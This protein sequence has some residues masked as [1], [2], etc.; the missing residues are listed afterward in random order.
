MSLCKVTASQI[1]IPKLKFWLV[2]EHSSQ[3]TEAVPGWTGAVVLCF[4]VFLGFT[5]SFLVLQVTSKSKSLFV[6]RH[7]PLPGQTL[8]LAA[9]CSG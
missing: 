8:L 3:H 5:A 4:L 2:A 6:T 9:L 1:H 7:L